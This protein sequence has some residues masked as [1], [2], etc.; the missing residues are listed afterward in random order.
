M[1]ENRS[2]FVWMVCMD[3][4]IE[5]ETVDALGCDVFIAGTHKWLHGPRGTGI[6]YAKSSIWQY[7]RTTIP[8]FSGNYDGYRITPGGFHSFANRW[9]LKDAFNF[10]LNIGKSKIESRIHDL[11]TQLKEG[12]N[13]LSRVSL[14]TP[15]SSDL[16][17]GIN[18]FNVSGQS[19][20]QTVYDLRRWGIIGSQSPYSPSYVRLTPGLLNNPEQVDRAIQVVRS[21]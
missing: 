16:S 12:L 7:L 1:N 20:S 10:M 9:A 6:I 19:V 15:I 11:N 13:K 14:H 4:G 17:A 18:C 21:L 3:F 8:S 5:N 2:C